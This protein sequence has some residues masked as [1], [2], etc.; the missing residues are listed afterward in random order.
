MGDGG[1]VST[2]RVNI[3]RDSRIQLSARINPAVR[4]YRGREEQR[5]RRDSFELQIDRQT[6]QIIEPAGLGKSHLKFGCSGDVMRTLSTAPSVFF[7][8]DGVT[9]AP[10]RY[11][12]NGDGTITDLNTR[13]MWEKKVAGTGCLHCVDDT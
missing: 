10:L 8:S 12:D 2:L 4:I 7:P 9:G 5:S 11:Q 1:F 3:S 13:L 6:T